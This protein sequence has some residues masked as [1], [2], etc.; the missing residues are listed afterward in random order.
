MISEIGGKTKPKTPID[1][2][3][4]SMTVDSNDSYYLEKKWCC[5]LSIK[6]KSKRHTGT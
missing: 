2:V 5:F 4:P 1:V 3:I 6:S